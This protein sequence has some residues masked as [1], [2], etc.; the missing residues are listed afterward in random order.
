MVIKIL[1]SGCKNCDRLEAVAREAVER[2][3]LDATIEHVR[4]FADIMSYGVMTTP[5]LVVDEQVKLAGRVPSV[6]EVVKILSASVG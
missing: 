6:D 2:L 3:G 1:G 5:A 4:D